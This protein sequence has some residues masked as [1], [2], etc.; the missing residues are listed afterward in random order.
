[1]SW[2]YSQA[3]VEEYSEDISSDGEPSALS[4]GKPTQL[5]SWC[6][7]KTMANCQL[8][9]SGMT[10]KPLTEDHGEAVLMSFLEAFPVRTLAAPAKAKAS[11]ETDHPC[12]NTWRESLEK[13]DLDTHTWKTHQCLW[14]E[15]LQ[16]SSVILP[17]WGMMRSGVL[18]ERTTLPRLTSGT[19]S[20]S[21]ATP[22]SSSAMAAN[23]SENLAARCADYGN[24]EEQVSLTMWPTPTCQEVEHPD[25]ELTDTGRRLSKDGQSSHSLNLADSVKKWPTPAARDYQ[26]TNNN[27]TLEQGRFVDQLPN[28]VKMIEQ[29]IPTPNAR[30]WKDSTQKSSMNALEAGSQMTLGRYV[31]KYPTPQA[32]EDAAGT[33][34]GNMQKMLGNDPRVPGETQEEWSKGALNPTWVEW[35]MGWPIGW[36]SMDAIEGLD[37]RGWE[38]DPADE[39]EVPRVATGIKHRVGRLKAIGNGQVPQVAAMAWN[40]LSK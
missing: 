39:G 37:W 33:P 1:M 4:N 22:R 36:T 16:P 25:A 14:D 3:L 31:H 32:N 21:W 15:D 9:Q 12:G 34:A 38:T 30:D 5:P 6:S 7:D 13:F 28:K 11:K 24:L 19:G 2:L 40:I 35:L 23:M 29:N 20:G 8:S 18:W 17:K 10:F 26:P 27:E